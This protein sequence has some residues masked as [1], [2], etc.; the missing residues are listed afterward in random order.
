[1]SNLKKIR[2]SIG[3]SQGTLSCLSGVSCRAIQAYES[4]Y[5]DINKAQGL[6]LRALAGVLFCRIEDIMEDDD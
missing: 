4:G 6:T 1:M 3:Y 2:K 5:R